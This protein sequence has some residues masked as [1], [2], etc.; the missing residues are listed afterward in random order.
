MEAR[1]GELE[2]KVADLER[3]LERAS[4]RLAAIEAIGQTALYASA[5]EEPQAIPSVA[6]PAQPPAGAAGSL[7]ALV[8]RGS[9]DVL[10]LVGRTFLVIGGAFLV[11]VIT[12]RDVVPRSVG[13]VLGLAFAST[14]VLLAWRA[15]AAGQRRNADFHAVAALL[16][17]F[18]LIVETGTRLGIMSPT[19]ASAVLVGFTFLLLAT[20]DRYRLELVAWAST[21]ASAC[22]ATLLFGAAEEPVAPLLALLGLALASAVLAERRGWTGLRWPVALALDILLIRGVTGAMSLA[23]VARGRALVPWLLAFAF[24]TVF[25]YLL[26]QVHR[27]ILQAR[28]AGP[29]EVVQPVLVMAAGL[30]ASRWAGAVLGWA[31]PVAGGVALGL[32]LWALFFAERLSRR[33]ARIRDAAVFGALGGA[34]VIAGGALLTSSVALALFWAALG[35]VLLLLGRRRSPA[36]WWAVGLALSVAAC[37]SGGVLAALRDG[38]VLTS[39]AAPLQPGLAAWGVL[40]L[41]VASAAA[42]AARRDVSMGARAFLSLGYLVLGGLGLAAGAAF[43][44]VAVAPSL[45]AHPAAL[46]LVRTLAL[47]GG[48]LGF[49]LAQRQVG[50]HDLG[51]AA[52]VFLGLAFVKLV[53]QDLPRGH[54]LSLVVAFSAFGGAMIALPRLLRRPR[55]D[56]PATPIPFEPTE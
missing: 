18:P 9:P 25:L 2:R 21:L 29:F 55:P 23:D 36:L 49:A 1:V 38:L 54:P 47:V 45:G 12:D 50:T 35:L 44:A 3:A 28:R 42:A 15:A 34:F 11:R 32:G 10:P 13:V 7:E 24:A 26:A 6:S 43:L 27:V 30:F 37:A 41:V 8:D 40:A 39:E 33:G 22:T 53:A 46:V 5:V 56:S 4:Q 17:G 16:V 19:V 20:A 31:S 52:F 48:V 14:W 51:W